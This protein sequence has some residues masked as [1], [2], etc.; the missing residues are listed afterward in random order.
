MDGC[1]TQQHLRDTHRGGGNEW[2]TLPQE[3]VCV[4]VCVVK[5]SGYMAVVFVA[6][7][8]QLLAM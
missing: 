2:Y 6:M 3:S 8:A 1:L 4:G 7:G 5:M